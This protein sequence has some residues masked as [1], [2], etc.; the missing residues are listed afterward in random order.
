VETQFDG[1]VNLM[2]NNKFWIGAGYRVQDAFVLMAGLE[3]IPNLKL[4]Y[5]Y[6]LTTSQI[7][8]Y[9]SGTHEIALG[10]CFNPVKAVKRQFH[11]NVRFL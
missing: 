9:S 10:Y 3:I 4:G 2:I 11:R 7:G 6:D 5:S 8:N 1:D